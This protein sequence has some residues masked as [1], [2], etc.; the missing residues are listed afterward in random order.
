MLNCRKQANDLTADIENELSKFLEN[1]TFVSSNCKKVF[2]SLQNVRFFDDHRALRLNF[3]TGARKNLWSMTARLVYE[4]ISDLTGSRIGSRS[5]FKEKQWCSCS[6][7]SQIFLWWKWLSGT[8][9]VFLL[10]TATHQMNDAG[11]RFISKLS[12]HYWM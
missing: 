11:K 8:C 7:F 9:I 6:L 3:G 12:L 4:F 5:V 1:E 2:R 10:C